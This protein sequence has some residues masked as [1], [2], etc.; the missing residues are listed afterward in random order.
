MNYN[1]ENNDD[2]ENYNKKEKEPEGKIKKT[3]SKTVTKHKNK[4]IKKNK[5]SK[6]KI[7]VVYKYRDKKSG[8]GFLIFLL[9]V[10][11]IGLAGV[12]VYLVYTN[13]NKEKEPTNN[14]VLKECIAKTTSSNFGGGLSQCSNSEFKLKLTDNDLSFDIIN[15]NASY[16]IDN[17]YYKD[18]K[19]NVWNTGINKVKINDNFQIKNMDGIIYLL[20]KSTSKNDNLIVIDNGK[21]IYHENENI[22]FDLSNKSYIKYTSLGLKDIDTCENYKSNNE[23]DSELYTKGKLVYNGSITLEKIEVITAKDVCTK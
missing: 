22:T 12:I 6:P 4:V 23:L 21:V 16:T 1:E 5:K 20:V 17:I 9:L 3:K 18:K 8:H 11:I 7:K 10:I 19:V 14:P 2:L 13:Q 15:N